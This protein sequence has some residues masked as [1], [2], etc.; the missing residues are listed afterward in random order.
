MQLPAS[1]VC[2][3]RTQEGETVAQAFEN[4][5]VLFSDIVGW[6]RVA[7]GGWQGRRLRAGPDE[8]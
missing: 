2:G 8:S 7:A 1:C 5:T 6:G 4:V 3:R